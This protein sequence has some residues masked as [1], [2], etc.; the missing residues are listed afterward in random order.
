MNRWLLNNL[1]TWELGLL[2]VGAFVL[3]ALVG[4]WLTWRWL[5]TL[6]DGESN[7]VAGVILGVLAAVYGIVLAFVIVALYEEYRTANNDVRT[8]ATALSKVYR[9]S[10]AFGPAG[11]IAVKTAVGTYI[12]SVVTD[13]WPKLK[14]G[15]E[16][17]ESWTALAGIYKAV[18]S[19]EPKTVD[20]K[21]F[22]T[23]AVGRVD[24]LAG[25]R[26][27]RLNDAEES[28]PTTFDVLLVGG[29]FLLLGVTFV[30]GTRNRRLHLVLTVSVA[31]LLG[32]NLLLALALDYPFSGS[33]AVSTHP[34]TQD[35]LGDFQHVLEPGRH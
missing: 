21:T 31:V 19:Y 2:I 34:F 11:R 8:E 9:D 10:Q 24:E 27:Q 35:A 14:H 12:K 28:L 25:A 26:R 22:Y 15:Q 17:K 20:Q 3:V 4:L 5:P 23:E 13:E 6:G 16:S 1:A 30:F 32:F 29:A 33:V 7:D 18:G